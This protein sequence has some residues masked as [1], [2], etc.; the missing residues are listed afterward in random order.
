[1]NLVKSMEETLNK[2]Y[3]TKE[4]KN[5]N[6]EKIK[7]SK[8]KEKVD[9]NPKI[10]DEM[11]EAKTHNKEDHDCDEVHPGESHKEWEKENK[12]EVEFDEGWKKGKYKVTDVKSGK[13]LGKF[14]SGGKAQKYVDDLFQKG[15]YEAISVELDEKVVYTR[16]VEIDE[17]FSMG[18]GE[19][20]VVDA[21]YDQKTIKAH[22]ASILTTDGQTLTKRGMGGQTIAQWLE[23][24]G[25]I[26]I[27]AVT[28]V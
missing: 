12:E 8:K 28:D 11:S 13:V 24:S 21:F 19:K 20:R 5:G 6:G 26:A 25:K 2:M 14:N 4:E 7:L 3:S 18:K 15:D 22:G 1:M 16:G 10:E 23:P 27:S 9:L 17:A